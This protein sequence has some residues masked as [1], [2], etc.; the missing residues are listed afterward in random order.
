[1]EKSTS[2]LLV[3]MYIFDTSAD[4]LLPF[5]LPEP[6]LFAENRL[7]P[8][9]K[10]ES[11]PSAQCKTTPFPMNEC[12]FCANLSHFANEYPLFEWM[13]FFLQRRF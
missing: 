9:V 2:L 13:D 7:A 5:V 1:M 10:L 11:M 8:I 4:A 3:S 6:T 12:H